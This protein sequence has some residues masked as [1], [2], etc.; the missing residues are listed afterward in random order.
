MKTQYLNSEQGRQLVENWQASGLSQKA[1]C[2]G[3]GVSY[4]RFHYWYAVY[5]SSL[6][7]EA[8]FLPVQVTPL[9]NYIVLR[10]SNGLELQMPSSGASAVFIKQLLT[11]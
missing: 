10:G 8:K 5:R 3:K 9:E 6:M 7:P 4:A 1:F 11:V 2:S